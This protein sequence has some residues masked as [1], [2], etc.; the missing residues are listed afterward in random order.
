MQT[1]T[2]VQLI[3]VSSLTQANSGEQPVA[4][5][6]RQ[7]P[8]VV[9][10]NS[11]TAVVKEMR[12]AALTNNNIE[13]TIDEIEAEYQRR[14]ALRCAEGLQLPPFTIGMTSPII[15]HA[16]NSGVGSRHMQPNGSRSVQTSVAPSHPGLVSSTNVGGVGHCSQSGSTQI[17]NPVESMHLDL[18]LERAHAASLESKLQSSN[19]E[20]QSM[21]NMMESMAQNMQAMQNM[22]INN[23]GTHMVDQSP[24]VKEKS[25]KQ[26]RKRSSTDS[27]DSDSFKHS[28]ASHESKKLHKKKRV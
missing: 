15:T 10:P 12:D 2:P 1:S 16:L 8:A 4:L 28:F 11:L 25:K 19:L 20:M 9:N 14:I 17:S 18:E 6:P 27:V 22:M 23:G 7:T 24:E 13:L 26:G 5:P 21:K 3:V